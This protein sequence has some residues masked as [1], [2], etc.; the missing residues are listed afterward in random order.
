[1]AAIVQGN[2]SSTVAR[3]AD[4]SRTYVLRGVT[5]SIFGRSFTIDQPV[6]VGRLPECDIQIEE[7]GLSRSHA[8]LSPTRDGILVQDLDSTNGTFVNDQ[9]VSRQMA[10]PGDEIRVDRVRFRVDRPLPA[11]TAAART[12]ARTAAGSGD[13]ASRRR[14]AIIVVLA[15]NAIALGAYYFL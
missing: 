8:R 4:P 11:K 2:A 14:W 5:G 1:M 10:L 3:D 13:G 12:Q 7:A 9:R 6:T 15:I